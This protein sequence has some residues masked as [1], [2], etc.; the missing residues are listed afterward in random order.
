M[1]NPYIERK[2]Y[3]ASVLIGRN[4]EFWYYFR[5]DGLM[6]NTRSF[7]EAFECPAGSRMNPQKKCGIW[8]N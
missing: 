3:L 4:H 7:N 8:T 5:V 6:M 2:K 1:N